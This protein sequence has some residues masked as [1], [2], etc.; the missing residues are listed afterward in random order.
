MTKGE[1]TT[2]QNTASQSAIP[3]NTTPPSTVPQSTS[4]KETGKV[5]E[6]STGIKA[7]NSYREFIER[8]ER[9]FEDDFQS[10]SVADL[11]INEVYNKYVSEKEFILE[12]DLLGYK[13]V[14]IDSDDVPELLLGTNG[15]SAGVLV[16]IYDIYKYE[17]DKMIHVYSAGSEDDSE[18]LDKLGGNFEFYRVEF[19]PFDMKLKEIE[20]QDS[21]DLQFSDLDGIEF[22]FS[23]GAG[24]WSTVVTIHPDGT[25]TGYYHDSNAGESG[26]LYPGGTCRE[27]NFQGKFSRMQKSGDFQYTFKCEYLNVEGSAGEERIEDGIRYIIAD[28]Y[29]FDNADEFILYLPGKPADELP[30]GFLGWSHDKAAHRKLSCYGLYNVGGEQGFVVWD[31]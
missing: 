30:E 15:R 10:V 23:S 31:Y 20:Y 8:L 1:N 17:D 22:M 18:E 4:Q 13:V 11:D 25:F 14:D 6:L 3:Q 19:K 5:R 26:V 9:A 27:C 28:P 16:G 24:A 2:P 12:Q 7:E 21:D 29:G